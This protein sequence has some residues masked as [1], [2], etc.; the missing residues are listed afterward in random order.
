MNVMFLLGL[1]YILIFK[2]HANE[3]I[4]NQDIDSQHHIHFQ[5][6]ANSIVLISRHVL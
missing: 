5:S 3:M 2:A 1:A 4:Q 6:V